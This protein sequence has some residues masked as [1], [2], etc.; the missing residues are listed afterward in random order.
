[1]CHGGI[2]F[3]SPFRI[4]SWIF[5]ILCCTVSPA[6]AVIDS[7]VD[8]RPDPK[9]ALYRVDIFAMVGTLVLSLCEGMCLTTAAIFPNNDDRDVTIF[10]LVT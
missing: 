3:L 9:K 4:P 5:A 7:E 10:V 8:G 1:M 6:G 2:T